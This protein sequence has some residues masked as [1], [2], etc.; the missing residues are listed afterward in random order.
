M[1]NAPLKADTSVTKAIL[2]GGLTK[3]DTGVV[4]GDSGEHATAT[5]APV[6]SVATKGCRNRSFIATR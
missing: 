6:T 2:P 4:G 5:S 1:Y 3:S